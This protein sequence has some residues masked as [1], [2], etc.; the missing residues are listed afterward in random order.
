MQEK[1]STLHQR[2]LCAIPRRNTLVRMP[3]PKSEQMATVPIEVIRT[4]ARWAKG[5]MEAHQL[6][7]QAALGEHM[8]KALRV[9]AIPQTTISRLLATIENGPKDGHAGT[10][11]ILPGVESLAQIA[12]FYGYEPLA[13][14][15]GTIL[16]NANRVDV[17]NPNRGAALF[18]LSDELSKEVIEAMRKLPIPEKSKRWTRRRWLSYF[19]ERKRDWDTGELELPGLGRR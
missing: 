2:R 3:R 11:K 6:T 1:F 8:G 16:A 12:G 5:T 7:S 18:F 10:G 4:I 15:D 9:D 19:E 17:M 14:F 13:L